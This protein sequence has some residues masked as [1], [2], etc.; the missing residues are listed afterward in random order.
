M[1]KRSPRRYELQRQ[2][3]ARDEELVA[4]AVEYCIAFREYRAAI[5]RNNES[6]SHAMLQQVRQCQACMDEAWLIFDRRMKANTTT[7]IGKQ[8]EAKSLFGGG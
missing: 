8:P 2:V 1:S 5:A 3:A 6:P 7:L 4:G